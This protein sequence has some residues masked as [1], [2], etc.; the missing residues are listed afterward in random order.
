M[1]MPTIKLTEGERY[2]FRVEKKLAIEEGSESFILKGPDNRKYLVPAE[3]Y[4]KY[5]IKPGK[6]LICRVD[7]INCKGEVF[8][9]PDNPWY[10][11]NH[12]YNFE[13]IGYR[14]MPGKNIRTGSVMMVKTLYDDVI[15]V[16]VAS[17]KGL[18]EPGHEVSL[19]VLKISKGRLHLATDSSISS[20]EHLDTEVEYE[21]EVVD[22]ET[23][24]EGEEYFIVSDEF[25][26]SHTLKRRYYEYYGLKEGVRFKGRV[27]KY[28]EDGS[29]MIEP[30]NPF[31]QPGQ[32]LEISIE[33]NEVNRL[34]GSVLIAGTDRYGQMHELR[35]GKKVSGSKILTRVIRIR[36][37]KPLLEPVL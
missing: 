11:E 30:E 9:E 13:I 33:R 12:R 37:G 21:F 1:S 5:D 18:P 27:V 36:K 17:R 32:L 7:K 35:L 2:T 25:G 19:L 8:L 26:V 10:S 16:P 22:T 24:F 6:D 28:R 34:D 3:R 14:S 23:D 4:R 29:K 15:A 20:S 31:Y